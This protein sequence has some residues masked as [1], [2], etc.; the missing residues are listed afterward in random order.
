MF[1]SKRYLCFM[2]LIVIITTLLITNQVHAKEKEMYIKINLF[3]NELI[4]MQDKNVIEKFPISVGT[5]LSPT[6]IGTYTIT[7]KAK[8]WGGGFG[9]R[10]IGLNVPWGIYGIHG[11]N[12]PNLIGESVSS[13]CIRMHNKDVEQLYEMIPLGTIVKITGSITGTGKGEFK[14][15]SVGSKGN[16]VQLVQSRLKSMGLYD[17]DIN[18]IY[19]IKTELAI[20]DFQKL[21][22]ISINGVVSFREYLLLG[23][24]E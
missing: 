8:S 22:E 9:S 10:W 6:P 14:N 15:L 1:M 11:T 4:V 17:G 20:K 21:N 12:K 13:G 16:L 24:I 18:G 7:E 5:E 3:T 23:L 2:I 19:G